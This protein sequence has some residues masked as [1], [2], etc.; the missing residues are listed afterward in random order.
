MDSKPYRG[1]KETALNANTH[2]LFQLNAIA[3]CEI[4]LFGKIFF[5]FC[6]FRRKSYHTIT[7]FSVKHCFGD[8]FFTFLCAF[9]IFVF[10][11]LLLQVT[12]DERGEIIQ[13]LR[14][15]TDLL[16]NLFYIRISFFP[17]SAVPLPDPSFSDKIDGVGRLLIGKDFSFDLGSSGRKKVRAL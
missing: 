4:L 17:S 16:S 6:Y 14:I 10:F 13:K 12:D 3:F 8:I 7:S 9:S 15:K 5:L 11:C 1:K 2:T